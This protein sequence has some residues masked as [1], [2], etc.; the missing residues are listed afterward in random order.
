MRHYGS[1]LG[2]SLYVFGLAAHER[3]RNQ[4]GEV[5]VLYV[6]GLEHLVQLLLHLLPD[7]IAVGFDDHTS[8]YGTLLGQVGF[9]H[10]VVIP[11]TVIIS[12]FR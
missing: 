10:Q 6:L 7:G 5:G 12:S 11:L 4:Q 2:K 9:H 3:L 1:L 8:A